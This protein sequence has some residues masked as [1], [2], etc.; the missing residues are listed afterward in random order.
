M[1]GIFTWM[2]VNQGT[3]GIRIDLT[4]LS[5]REELFV[6]SLLHSRPI[7]RGLYAQP[8]NKMCKRFWIKIE[9]TESYQIVWTWS[10]SRFLLLS[11]RNFCTVSQVFREAA[12]KPW[13]S[14]NTNRGFSSQVYPW[15]ISALP[16]RSCAMSIS[17]D[18]S[19]TIK[20]KEDEYLPPNWCWRYC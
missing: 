1:T 7:A 9:Q 5:K 16:A 11:R 3:W 18:Q 20:R 6:T 12:S 14:C 8:V 2:R 10:G 15:L 17:Y 19:N 13:L 4:F